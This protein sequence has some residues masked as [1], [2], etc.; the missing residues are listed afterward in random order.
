MSITDE[1]LKKAYKKAVKIHKKHLADDNVKLPDWGSGKGYWL[2]VLIH[3]SP[4][5]VHKDVMSAIVRKY[6][7]KAGTDQQVRH[8]SRDGWNLEGDGKGAHRIKDA[9]LVHQGYAVEKT[10]S[11]NLLNADDFDAIKAAYDNKCVSCGATEGEESPRYQG[12]GIVKLQKGHRDPELPMK[13][14]NV[15]PQCQFCN[16]AYKNDFTFDKK[17]RVRAVADP[18]PVLRASKTVK[19]KV[20][21]ALKE[22]TKKNAGEKMPARKK[23]PK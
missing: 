3:Y 8:L 12:D 19:A 15:I 21:T 22:E 18:R 7:P 10:R 1:E 11:E 14:G 6:N 17:G 23:P 5:F 20:M 16:R 2:A 9:R 4:K 13:K